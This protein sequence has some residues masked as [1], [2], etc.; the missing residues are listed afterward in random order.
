MLHM[1]KSPKKNIKI[2]VPCWNLFHIDKSILC[3]G[4]DLNKEFT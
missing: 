4:N 2:I 1:Q 3:M